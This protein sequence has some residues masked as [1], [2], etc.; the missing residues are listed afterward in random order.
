M[1]AFLRLCYVT[2]DKKNKQSSD[3]SKSAMLFPCS[4]CF[5]TP[6]LYC[7]AS[8]NVAILDKRIEISA[9]LVYP[10]TNTQ[11]NFY[12][13]FRDIPMV[14]GRQWSTRQSY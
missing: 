6:P 12:C 7:P 13:I 5:D 11:K 8:E 14:N 3:A 10:F 9:F 2:Q 1:S 4:S